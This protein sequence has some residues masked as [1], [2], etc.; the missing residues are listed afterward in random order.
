MTLIGG[1]FL[2][3]N[4][5]QSSYR[6]DVV[7]IARAI[8][9]A[10]SGVRPWTTSVRVGIAGFAVAPSAIVLIASIASIASAQL[11]TSSGNPASG[12]AAGVAPAVDSVDL[13]ANDST[14]EPWSFGIWF[15]GGTHEPLKTRE[16]HKADR[17]LYFG[18]MQV[19]H[20]ILR[21]SFAVVSYT[22][23]LMPAIIATANRDY[24]TIAYPNG[25]SGT[26]VSKTTAFG[27]GFLPV[28]LEAKLFVSN[29]SGLVIGGGGGAAYFDRR[30]PDPAETRFNFLANGHAGLYFRSVV[31][32]TT[33]GF[34]LQ[35]VSNG[36]T[37]QVNPGM[38]SRMLYVGFS[39]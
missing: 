16:G 39:R 8:G 19:A 32:T 37:G 3:Q 25:R 26:I 35:H 15:A 31:G 21:S 5:R 9:M 10:A 20:L 29:R 1:T 17:A 28:A 38:D 33:V 36:N 11:P 34:W 4:I 13:A 30:I 22:P 14:F 12:D 7:R 27:V 23:A 2:V 6:S 24:T 18:G